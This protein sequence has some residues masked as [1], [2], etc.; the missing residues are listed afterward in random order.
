MAR[1]YSNRS[2]GKTRSKKKPQNSG[3]RK[4]TTPKKRR[5]APKKNTRKASGTPGWVW[6]GS[7]LFLGLTVAAIFY[8]ASR[9]TSNPGRDSS[10]INV[11]QPEQ[12]KK[13]PEEP[14]QAPKQ[15]DEQPKYAF[16][17]MLHD[18]EVVVPGEKSESN[19]T[20]SNS[21]SDSHTT[22]DS[23][24]TPTTNADT[25][26]QADTTEQYV[27]Q[28]GAFSTSED[29]NQLKAQ[30]ALLGLHTNIV[31]AERDS[32]EAIYRVRSDVIESNNQLTEMLKR[33]HDHDIDTLVLQRSQ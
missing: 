15:K 11:P 21:N 25:A 22:T 1:D 7:G 16:Y 14:K 31:R 19:T 3:T 2:G 13:A 8:I 23:T 10:E 6:L 32:G 29:A 27:I 24:P 5:N 33:L 4:K 9:P 17:E 30:V 28:V 12:V 20:P 26:E 18:Y